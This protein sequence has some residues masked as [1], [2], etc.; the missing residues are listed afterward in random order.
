MYL[1]GGKI[2]KQFYV[3]FLH[4][5]TQLYPQ[6][7]MYLILMFVTVGKKRNLFLILRR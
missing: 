7:V 5:Q 2:W 4:T 3:V 6:L 1:Y